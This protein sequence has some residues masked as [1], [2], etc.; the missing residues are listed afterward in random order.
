[1]KVDL[2]SGIYERYGLEK[3]IADAKRIGYD[4]IQI[5]CFGN[6]G[7]EVYN[8]A[9]VDTIKDYIDN[10]DIEV[11]CLYSR[12]GNYSE[13]DT[14]ECEEEIKKLEWICKTAQ[15]LGADYI[16][17]ISGIKYGAGENTI[18]KCVNWYKRAADTAARYNKKLV[19]EIHNG[20]YI[21]SV[22]G[23]KD[24]I[25]RINR[26]NVGYIYDATNMYI[27]GEEYGSDALLQILSK[28]WIF[29]IKNMAEVHNNSDTDPTIRELYGKKFKYTYIDEGDVD[30]ALLIKVLKE[31]NFNGPLT[32]ENHR[33]CDDGVKIAEREFRT[34]KKILSQVVNT[35]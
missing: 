34:I 26:E 32:L 20:A 17:H 5:R 27:C 28:V 7:L 35:Q 30:F 19:M 21:Q 4:S 31:N 8:D 6:E 25:E 22:R 12:T 13:K 15:K 24:L 33:K 3:C 14:M 1:M 23:A 16:M 11:S 18:D 29:H 9:R 10:T 2:F